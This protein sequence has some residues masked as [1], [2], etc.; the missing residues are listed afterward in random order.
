MLGLFLE[1]CFCS[2]QEHRSADVQEHTFFFFTLAN[3]NRSES[4]I[5]QQ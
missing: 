4:N 1:V 3:I 5:N 2:A